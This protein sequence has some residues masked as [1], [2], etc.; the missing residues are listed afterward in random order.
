MNALDRF[1]GPAWVA[2]A[3]TLASYGLVLAVLFALLFVVPFFAFS[4]PL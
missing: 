1:D 2:A 4:G 3:A